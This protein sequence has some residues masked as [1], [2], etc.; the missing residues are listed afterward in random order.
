VAEDRLKAKVMLR[1]IVDSEGGKVFSFSTIDE[2]H[3]AVT[4]LLAPDIFRELHSPPELHLV[5]RRRLRRDRR[6]VR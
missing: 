2:P 4:V 6:R 1:G 5:L 3:P